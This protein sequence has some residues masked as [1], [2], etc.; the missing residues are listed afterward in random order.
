MPSRLRGKPDVKLLT[1]YQRTL[2]PQFPGVELPE[3]RGGIVALSGAVEISL[4]YRRRRRH[5]RQCQPSQG[6]AVA[7]TTF[8]LDANLRL[9]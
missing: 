9:I 5:R 7:R 2:K 8:F 1:G 6:A 4:P 3:L